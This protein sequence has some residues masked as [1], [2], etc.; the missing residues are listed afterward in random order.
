MKETNSRISRRDFIKGAAA[1]AMGMAAMGVLGACSPTVTDPS[2]SE[3]STQAQAQSQSPAASPLPVV[4]ESA[5]FFAKPQP[6]AESEITEVLDADMVVVGAGNGGVVSALT[7]LEEGASV[8]LLEKNATPCM[9]AGEMSALNTRAAKSF[10]VEYT[11]EERNEIVNDICR[12]ASFRNDMRLVKLWAEKSC[13]TMDWY[14]DKMESKGLSMFVET[15]LKDTHY[16]SPAVTH[17]VYKEPFNE[18]GPNQMG[19]ELAMPYWI[20]L[21]EEAGGIIKYLCVAEQLLQDASGKITGIVVKDEDAGT[22]FQINVT[23]GVVLSTGGYSGNVEMMDALNVGNHR[24]YTST[25]GDMG[26]TGDGIKMALWAGADMDYDHA[27]GVNAFDRGIVAKDRHLGPPY[28]NS[29]NDLWWPGSQ[30][31]LKVNIRGERFGNEDGPYDFEIHNGQ[32]QPGHYWWQVFDSN[33]WEDVNS[34]HTTIC[35]RVVATKGARNSIVVGVWPAKSEEEFYDLFMKPALE[36]E[37]LL[38]ADSLEELAEKMEVPVDTFLATTSRYN[39]LAEKGVDEDFGKKDIRLRPI[40]KGPF[41]AIALGGWILHTFNGIRV[42]TNLEAIDAAGDPIEGLYVVGNDMGG[43][44]ANSYP[45]YYGGLAHGKTVC[46]ARL[47]VLHAMN[48]SY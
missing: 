25:L 10:G 13:E 16:N 19:T 4:S 9:W 31:W 17:T 22:Y 24:M 21:I 11:L 5:D 29:P 41:Y 7:A 48:G 46:F 2:S 38:Q 6:I 32:M 36:N 34:F 47:A 18:L 1:G 27:G 3:E 23:K 39:E 30:P 40:A 42:N 12:Y 35:S 45:Q 26:R 33:Y 14:T 44:F 28:G 37:N 43:F 15:D 8:I 20:E